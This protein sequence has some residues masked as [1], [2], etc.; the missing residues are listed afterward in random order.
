MDSD[1]LETIGLGLAVIGLVIVAARQLN[2]MWLDSAEGDR[3]REAPTR[4][5]RKK[6]ASKAK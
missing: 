1:T 2:Y 5:A 6:E 3:C 4:E